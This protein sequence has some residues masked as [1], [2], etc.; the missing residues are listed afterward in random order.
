[1]AGI[2]KASKILNKNGVIFF[3]APSADSFLMQYVSQFPFGATRYIES[4]RHYLFLSRKSID[5]ICDKYGLQLAHIESNGL[6]IQ[7][8]L[9]EEFNDEITNKMINIQDVLNGMLLG[10]HYRV[11][12][13]KYSD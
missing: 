13:R 11:F 2:E 10:D 4:A 3:E 1:M 8:I 9:L 12:L 5:F 6:D 7:T